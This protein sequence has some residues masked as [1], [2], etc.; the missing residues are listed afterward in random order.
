M[1]TLLF[2]AKMLLLEGKLR[3]QPPLPWEGRLIWLP[4]LVRSQVE[5]ARL[6]AALRHVA[7]LVK[8][9]GARVRVAAD[10]KVRGG[11]SAAEG[12]ETLRSLSR[13]RAA[14]SVAS[15]LFRRLGLP[16]RPLRPVAGVAAPHRIRPGSPPRP[17]MQPP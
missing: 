3:Y 11:Q 6:G 12:G 13:V 8:A 17:T 10:V 4:S 15:P 14:G 16:C 5:G 7:V 2:F 1:R 9:V